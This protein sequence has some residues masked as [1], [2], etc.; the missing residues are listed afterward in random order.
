MFFFS[1]CICSRVS[2]F[3]CV[4][5]LWFSVLDLVVSFRNIEISTKTYLCLVVYLMNFAHRFLKIY[6]YFKQS[7]IKLEQEKRE[8]KQQP[9]LY[10]SKSFIL[11]LESGLYLYVFV[12][13]RCVELAGSSCFNPLTPLSLTKTLMG[14]AV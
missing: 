11:F 9:C 12:F 10:H 13:A 4:F 2:V 1:F 8:K 3:G 7:S 14:A 6:A 5:C